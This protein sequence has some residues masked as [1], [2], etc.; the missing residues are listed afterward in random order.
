MQAQHKCPKMDLGAPLPMTILD[1]PLPC[2]SDS[3]RRLTDGSA[4]IYLHALLHKSQRKKTK[5]AA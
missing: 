5:K 3:R 2:I 1:F 4:N